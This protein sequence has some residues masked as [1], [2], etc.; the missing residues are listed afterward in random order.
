MPLPT[1]SGL[2]SGEVFGGS[3]S[4]ESSS[5]DGGAS[6]SA[7]TVVLNIPL[8]GLNQYVN[9]AK[10]AEERYGFNALHPRL[11][12]QKE[13]LARVAAAGAALENAHKLGQGQSTGSA[14]D[15]SVDL[16]NDEGDDSNVE[17]GGMGNDGKSGGDE[18]TGRDQPVVKQR[19]KRVM[20]EDMYDKDDDFIDDTEQAWE[21]QA[22]VAKDGFFVYSGLLVPEG[23]E[24]KVERYVSFSFLNLSIF[25]HSP[26]FRSPE[27][28]TDL[29]SSPQCR[30]AYPPKHHHN[31]HPNTRDR[32]RTRWLAGPRRRP[33]ITRGTRRRDH[34]R[35]PSSAGRASCRHR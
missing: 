9:F 26:L 11:A 4:L 8:T 20:K 13:R 22:A 31:H 17:M 15:K 21:E 34:G 16:S 7:P 33:R 1:G 25:T 28:D 29:P 12:A 10:L 23:E 27:H 3:S 5:K 2:L 14:D 35:H 24:A 18:E 6:S 32:H 19:R 30:S